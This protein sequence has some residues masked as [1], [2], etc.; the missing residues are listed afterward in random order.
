MSSTFIQRTKMIQDEVVF[1]ITIQGFQYR[2]N[3]FIDMQE[4]RIHT[5]LHILK[6]SYF[7]LIMFVATT[8]IPST[9]FTP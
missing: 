2:M 9:H 8:P 4:N 5:V 3:I 7:I 6:Q 1:N